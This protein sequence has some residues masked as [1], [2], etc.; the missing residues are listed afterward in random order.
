[1]SRESEIFRVMRLLCRSLLCMHVCDRRTG[2]TVKQKHFLARQSWL[3]GILL[4]VTLLVALA[5]CSGTSDSANRS[6][7]DTET[8]VLGP[9]AVGEVVRIGSIDYELLD[10]AVGG[11][12]AIRLSEVQSFMN[13]GTLAAEGHVYVN[14]S[15][16]VVGLQFDPN[17]PYSAVFS[18]LSGLEVVAGG[19]RSPG[20]GLEIESTAPETPSIVVVSQF[21]LPQDVETAELRVPATGEAATEV[22]FTLW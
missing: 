10:V 9:H 11:P 22:A 1:M 13:P 18:A 4:V 16:R 17:D 6:G 20:V 2:T 19:Q 8:R 5:A 7:G 15:L 21:E 14:V 12:S 3:A